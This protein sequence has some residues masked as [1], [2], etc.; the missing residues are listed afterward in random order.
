MALS[1]ENP[2]GEP[3]SPQPTPD[4]NLRLILEKWPAVELMLEQSGL[5]AELVTEVRD[6]VKDL[7]DEASTISLLRKVMVG[8]AIFYVIFVNMLLVCML[9]Y[10]QAFFIFIGPYGRVAL[11]LAAISSSVII[12]VKILA[13]LFRTHGDRNKDEMLPPH[14]QQLLEVFKATQGN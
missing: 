5:N 13:G 10:H 8:I 1:G 7:R 12:V 6:Y 3:S 4:E 9:F 14:L 11:I 2:L